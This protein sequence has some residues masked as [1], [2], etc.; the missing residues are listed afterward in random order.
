LLDADIE[1]PEPSTLERL[2]FTSEMQ[3]FM[4]SAVKVG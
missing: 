3:R 1:F 4:L 2:E